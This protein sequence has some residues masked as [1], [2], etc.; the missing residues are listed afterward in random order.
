MKFCY[1]KIRTLT[2]DNF[3]EI[4]EIGG[5]CGFNLGI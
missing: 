1:E 4:G 5:I 2:P 3:L